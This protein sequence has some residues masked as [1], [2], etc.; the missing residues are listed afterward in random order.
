[1]GVIL[2]FL[3]H[4]FSTCSH[5]KMQE[6]LDYEGLYISFNV[7][8]YYNDG[9]FEITF[10]HNLYGKHEII[11]RCMKVSNLNKEIIKEYIKLLISHDSKGLLFVEKDRGQLLIGRLYVKRKKENNK[12]NE[13]NNTQSIDDKYIELTNLIKNKNDIDD[14]DKS[15]VNKN[16]NIIKN[17]HTIDINENKDP[18]IVDNILEQSASGL[19]HFQIIERFK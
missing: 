2:S 13:L 5:T 18:E 1:M 16:K 6:T 4:I 9:Y 10:R 11:S 12:E 7:T 8:R 3:K 15:Y 19:E 14:K 17:D